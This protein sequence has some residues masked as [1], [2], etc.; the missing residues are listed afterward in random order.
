MKIYTKRGDTGMTDMRGE[1]V[2]KADPRVVAV[3]LLDKLNSHIGMCEMEEHLKNEIQSIIFDIGA[4]VYQGT[5]FDRDTTLL[6]EL[7]DDLEIMMSPLTKFILPRGNIHCAR[8]VCRD[9]ERHFVSEFFDMP[10]TIKYLNRLSDYLFVLAR[11]NQKDVA[12]YDSK[13]KP[14]TKYSD[15][16]KDWTTF[17]CIATPLLIIWILFFMLRCN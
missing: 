16:Q 1:R 11:Y 8:A 9:V 15:I 3:G 10:N 14:V 7:I 4:C 12:Y 5:D 13:R 17:D 6:E 2:T